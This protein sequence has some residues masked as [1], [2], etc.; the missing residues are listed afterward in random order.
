MSNDD[1][2]DVNLL[3]THFDLDVDFQELWKRKKA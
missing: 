1:D 2:V 3:L